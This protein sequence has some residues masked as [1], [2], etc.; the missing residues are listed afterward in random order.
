MHHFERVFGPQYM[1]SV[2]GAGVTP[3]LLGKCHL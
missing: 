1:L 2:P 3:G